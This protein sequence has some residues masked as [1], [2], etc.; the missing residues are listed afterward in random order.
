MI[1]TSVAS[2]RAIWL[3]DINDLNPRG[4]Y[5]YDQLFPW[6]VERYRFAQV[7][8][9]SRDQVD[10]AWQFL[11]GMFVNRANTPINVTLKV[12]NDG[13]VSE[14]RSSTDDSEAF[15]TD[16]L[17]AGVEQLGLTFTGS[18]VHRRMYASELNL[19]SD[20]AL[21]AINPRMHEF[22]NALSE[23]VGMKCEPT[24]LAFGGEP[25]SQAIFRFERKANVPFS[26]NKYW[27][28]AALST[29]DHLALLERLE[30]LLTA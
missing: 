10:N 27:S 30:A 2:A 29:S 21:D 17:T 25:V 22:L 15:L 13:L 11:D 6:L 20:K 26:Q 19:A 1:V 5:I 9:H 4:R 24:S 28:L 18:M 8:S 3:F 16:A 12:Y 14:T 7:P 23:A